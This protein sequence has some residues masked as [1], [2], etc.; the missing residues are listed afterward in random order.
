MIDPGYFVATALDLSKRDNTAAKAR[1]GVRTVVLGNHA[2]QTRVLGPNRK[3]PVSRREPVVVRWP[4]DASPLA[5]HRWFG[6]NI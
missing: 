1:V 3:H 4:A 2:V 5:G 6:D